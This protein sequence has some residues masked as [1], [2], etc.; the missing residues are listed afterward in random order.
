[1]PKQVVI[2]VM[3]EGYQIMVLLV[4]E[5]R[6]LEIKRKIKELHDEYYSDDFQESGQ[7]DEFN[8]YVEYIESELA[9]EEFDDI[10][11]IEYSELDVNFSWK[12]LS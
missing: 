10:K 2:R 8:G 4:P 9:K 11:S 6:E 7:V 3:D 12:M 1:M 5:E